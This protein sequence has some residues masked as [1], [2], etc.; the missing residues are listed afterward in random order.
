MPQRRLL[1]AAQIAV[2]E[3]AR[4]TGS[5]ASRRTSSR[6][7]SAA[8]RRVWPD[9]SVARP[10]TLRCLFFEQH[11][12]PVRGLDLDN[13][14]GPVLARPLDSHLESQASPLAGSDRSVHVANAELP[15]QAGRCRS[16]R[17]RHGG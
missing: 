7:M 15:G 3:R 10:S 14:I 11:V 2:H 16:E 9:Q 5:L 1:A 6:Q 17:A 8:G 12:H 4:I 13:P